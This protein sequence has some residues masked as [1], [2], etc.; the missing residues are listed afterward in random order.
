MSALISETSARSAISLALAAQLRALRSELGAPGKPKRGQVHRLR[1]ATRRLLAALDLAR[2]SGAVVP[3]AA[4]R[5]L[6]KLLDGLSP[7]RDAQVMARGLE[8]LPESA[9]R[10]TLLERVERQQRQ[11]RAR[12]AKRLR[13]F[14]ADKL[15][16]HVSRVGEWVAAGERPAPRLGELAVTG[17]LAQQQLSI[18]LQRARAQQAS[19]R[20]LHRL[21]LSL[22]AYR[23]TLE[24]LAGQLPQTAR[25]LLELSTQ[26]QDEL[27]QAHDRHVLCE[28]VTEHAETRDDEPARRLAALLAESSREAH[29]RAAQ[30]VERAKLDWPL[31]LRGADS[32]VSRTK[33]AP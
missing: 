14:D 30:Q 20:E 5:R 16:A 2:A 28:L 3:G 9:A 18:D 13:R 6:E 10:S 32:E 21:R 1:V 29:A 15:A 11:Q 7:L 12:T 19:P 23:Y 24:I 25:A 26:L 27:G 8:Q 4:P 17:F 33:S 31:A 22:K